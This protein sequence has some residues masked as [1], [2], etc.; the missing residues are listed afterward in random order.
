M[1]KVTNTNPKSRVFTLLEVETLDLLLRGR[2]RKVT[3]E[4]N[5][6]NMDK[7]DG[8]YSEGQGGK[9]GSESKEMRKKIGR[10]W[11]LRKLATAL[12]IRKENVSQSTRNIFL[13]LLI[14]NSSERCKS[15]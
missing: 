5:E 7:R 13:F 14:I 1:N 10:M 6:V 9:G 15:W 11:E 8:S 2:G 4:R 3:G 12:L